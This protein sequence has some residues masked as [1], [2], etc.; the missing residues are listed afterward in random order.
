MAE[1]IANSE[2]AL[3]KMLGD[4]RELWRQ[5]KFLRVAAKTGKARSLPQNAIQHAWY[6]QM[7]MED[8]SDD[9]QGHIRY[10]KLR[11]GVPILC[12]DDPEYREQCRRLLGPLTHEARLE[13]MDFFPVTRLMT[14]AQ[15]SRYL[16]AVRT[17]YLSNRGIQLEFPETTDA[18]LPRKAAR[19]D[20]P[21]GAMRVPV[22][23]DEE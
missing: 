20:A 19:N 5:H 21:G 10:C 9:A 12:A 7:A 15:E 16:E 6:T 3:H 8:R 13:A 17:D 18:R 14:K 2:P 22:S 11:H 23:R 1:W 4:L